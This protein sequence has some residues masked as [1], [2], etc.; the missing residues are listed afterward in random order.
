[1]GMYI[2]HVVESLILSPVETELLKDDPCHLLR[3]YRQKEKKGLLLEFKYLFIS[4]VN[5]II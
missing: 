2:V 3:I 4:V 5:I 1:M